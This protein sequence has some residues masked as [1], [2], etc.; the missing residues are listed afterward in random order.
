M[1]KFTYQYPVKQYFG[2]GCL[3][4]SLKSELQSMGKTVML[5][6]GSGSLKRTGLY[7]RI[8]NILEEGGKTV[9]DFG[10]IMPNPTYAKVQAG[11]RAAR[12]NKVDFILAVGGGSVTDCCKIISAQSQT[13]EDIWDM[14]YTENRIPTR[15][16]PIGAI[17]T[18]S[19]T[20]AEQ[21]NGAVITHEDKRLKQ[22]LFGAYHRFAILDSDLTETLPMK[23]VVSG[24][25]DTLSHCMETYMG[26][27]F[28][29]NVSDDINEAIMRNVITNLRAVI[30]NPADDFARGE[31]M[32][33]SAMAENDMLKLGKITDFQC[34][35][36]EHAVGAYTD[37]NHGQGLAIINPVLYRHY[38][39]EGTEKLAKMARNVWGIIEA[40]DTITANAGIDALESFIKEIG[41]P[42]RWSEIGVTDEAIL[43]KAADSTVLTAGC[44]KRFTHDE[45]HEV[46]KETL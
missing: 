4:E 7:D 2:K 1:N 6:Y 46:L 18:A 31:L 25:F 21:N 26:Q 17:V 39:P 32:R 43:R 35:M 13:D 45:L 42:T 14:L 20:G 19:G 5:A 11:A 30:A 34:H 8:R 29:A 16:L 37:C 10:G 12:E 28:A 3:E 33:D 15:F 9:V 23:Q 22:P 44:C 38:L 36:L 40:D 41:L 27:P 24:A